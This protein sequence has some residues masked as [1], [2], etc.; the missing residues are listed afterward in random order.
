MLADQVVDAIHDSALKLLRERIAAGSCTIDGLSC[1][2]GMSP[3]SVRYI[4]AGTRRGAAKSLSALVR[5]AGISRDQVFDL[6]GVC[7]F[8]PGRTNLAWPGIDPWTIGGGARAYE[9]QRKGG[10][11]RRAPEPL[12]WPTKH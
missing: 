1:A 11:R 10:P 5:A 4:L 9:M 12:W 3:V 7:G 6:A 8:C 2:V